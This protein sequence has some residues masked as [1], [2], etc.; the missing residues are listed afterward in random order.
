MSSRCLSNEPDAWCWHQTSDLTACAGL[1]T[2]LGA[3]CESHGDA[4]QC[5]VAAVALAVAD[6]EAGGALVELHVMGQPNQSVTR[7]PVS[8]KTLN[9]TKRV[10]P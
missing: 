2:C 8:H 5:L 4:L 6:G 7:Q 3:V 10:E 9:E 1:R